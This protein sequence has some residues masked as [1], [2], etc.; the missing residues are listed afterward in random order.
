MNARD[1]FF[2]IGTGRSGTT[3]IQRM[4]CAHPL[5]AVPPETQFFSRFDP[6]LEFTDPL[7]D[8][9]VDAYIDRVTQNEWFTELSLDEKQLRDAV[10][11][12][13]RSSRDLFLWMLGELVGETEPGVHVGEKTPHHEKH[14]PRL[15]A[16]FPG[17]VFIHIV[18]DPRDVVVS[19][20]KEEWWPWS[21]VLRTAL[22]V[23]K[24]LERQ[25]TC[26]SALGGRYLVLRYEDL[27]ESPERELRRA[28]ALLGVEFDPA[29]LAYHERD[30]TATL[31]SEDGWKALTREPL[32]QSR[33]GRWRSRL[34][35][36]EAQAIER[37][38]GKAMRLCGYE[39]EMPR[40]AFG[41]M[42]D[43]VERASW[44][45][46]RQWKSVRKRVS[47]SGV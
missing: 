10:A 30:D 12:D 43:V 32:D 46:S 27:V 19:L 18:R 37:V 25:R 36:R 9:D 44:F 3:L 41:P 29:M 11:S 7:R 35:T 28:C 16:L 14:V 17:A 1:P 47:H 39:P 45:F 24:T 21:S 2:I 33:M 38:C 22:A 15:A 42:L 26:A 23:R 4:L 40:A 5:L 31:P 20:R 8:E 34:S 13:V 6:A